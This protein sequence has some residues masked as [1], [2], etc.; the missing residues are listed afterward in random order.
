M[1]LAV[2]HDITHTTREAW[3]DA[4]VGLMRPE[5]EAAGVEL[6]E[7]V[8]TSA[9]FPPR[10]GL[11]EK[12]RT[13]GCCMYGTDGSAH[14]FLNPTEDL[15]V[16]IFGVLR[17]ELVHAALGKDV[18]DHG[19]K[20]KALGLRLGLE[21]KPREMF[22]KLEV[23]DRFNSHMLP[24]LGW[25]PHIRLEPNMKKKKQTTRMLK[26]VCDG[27]ET[28]QGSLNTSLAHDEYVLRGSKTQLERGVP[29][30]PVCE[31]D[32]NMEEHEEDQDD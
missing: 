27:C 32:M 17:H 7:T 8:K 30:C 10:G 5:F 28:A 29:Q 11:A 20:F 9:G 4:L 25:Y 23:L 1:G 19:P 26:I 18:E 22:P 2:E 15:P 24:G 16:D 21:G 12:T 13:R 31:L 14:V 3:L 6:P